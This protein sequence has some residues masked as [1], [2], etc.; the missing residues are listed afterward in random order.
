VHTSV[1]AVVMYFAVPIAR[2]LDV[3]CRD[4]PPA[5]SFLFSTTHRKTI[6]N[7]T[8][9]ILILPGDQIWTARDTVVI[10]CTGKWYNCNGKRQ[11]IPRS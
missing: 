3:L 11:R 7:V 8:F 6:H 2:C 10:V 1:V 4:N 5:Y 9:Q